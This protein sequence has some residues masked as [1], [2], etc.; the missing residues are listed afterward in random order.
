M[1]DLCGGEGLGPSGPGFEGGVDCGG[2]GGA[3]DG[4]EDA[5]PEEGR[6]GVVG[7]EVGFGSGGHGVDT[8]CDTA[9]VCGIRIDQQLLVLQDFSRFGMVEVSAAFLSFLFGLALAAEYCT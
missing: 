6:E 9:L 8:D 1:Q 7:E 3:E 2:G 4:D 5:Q